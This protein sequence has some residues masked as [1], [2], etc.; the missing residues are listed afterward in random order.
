ML[1]QEFMKTLADK[2]RAEK[3]EEEE[4]RPDAAGAERLRIRAASDGPGAQPSA[5]RSR[6][7]ALRELLLW[8]EEAVRVAGGVG[9]ACS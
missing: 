4:E 9:I 8:V 5:I 2:R 1:M 6:A 3:K 7:G